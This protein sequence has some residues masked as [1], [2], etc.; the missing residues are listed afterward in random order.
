M[1]FLISRAMNPWIRRF[2]SALFCE[3]DVS[4]LEPDRLQLAP[5]SYLTQSNS[6]VVLQKSTNPKIRHV[7]LDYYL[8][9][10]QLDGF[11]WGLNLTKRLEKH[12]FEMFLQ[13]PSDFV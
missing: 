8:H 10:E 7:I 12:I 6:Q 2:L 1:R 3:H 11:V 4:G 9:V 5:R 13:E